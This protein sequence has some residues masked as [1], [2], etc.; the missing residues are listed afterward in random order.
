MTLDILNIVQLG[1]ERVLD[2][3]DEDLPV[4]LAFIDERHDSKD[5]NLLNLAS[6]AKLL[7]D[8]ADV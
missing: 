3:N 8:L 7:A 1:R 2:V 5:L 6:V 4:G